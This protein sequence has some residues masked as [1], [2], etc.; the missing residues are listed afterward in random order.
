VIRAGDKAWHSWGMLTK[1]RTAGIG[2]VLLAVAI[3]IAGCSASGHG[4]SIQPQAV[5]G[6]GAVAQ[7]SSGSSKSTGTTGTRLDVITGS[8]VIRTKNP[9]AAAG[10]AASIVDKAGGRVDDRN[11]VAATRTTPA[12]AQL[13]L[14]IPA[15]KLTPTLAALKKVG[16][17]V[18]ITQSTSDVTTTSEDLGARITA[19]QTSIARLLALEAKATN[20]ADVIQLEN[21]ISDRQ[22]D[23]ESLQA[24]QRTLNDQIAMA[25]IKLHLI[26]P[27]VVIA[28]AGPPSPATAFFAGLS[29]FQVF[30]TWA[31]LVLTYLAPWIVLGAIIWI[32][33]VVLVRVRRR[34]RGA[35]PA[36]PTATAEAPPPPAA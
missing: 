26:A 2:A 8:V 11:Q 33:I 4:V 12:D 5:S 18:S 14:R 30:F 20:T 22:G 25:T 28:P 21:D 17:E 6:G 32:A 24:Q 13:T 16:S 34:R 3:S 19:L 27:S 35:E 10:E 23:L 36:T 9:I 1:R 15:S 7:D 31:F 29:G